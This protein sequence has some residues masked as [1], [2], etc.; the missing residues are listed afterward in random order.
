MLKEGLPQPFGTGASAIVL[1]VTSEHMNGAHLTSA[2]CRSGRTP[3][4][5]RSR[6]SD[7][8]E[9]LRRELTELEFKLLG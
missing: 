8:F 9:V 6:R 1:T 4:K 2:T 5:S 3:R 7:L